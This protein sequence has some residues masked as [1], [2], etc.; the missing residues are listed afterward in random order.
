MHKPLMGTYSRCLNLL[1][2]YWV[3]PFPYTMQ[4]VYCRLRRYYRDEYELILSETI[5]DGMGSD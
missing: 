3:S 1:L 2:V 5:D 4:E